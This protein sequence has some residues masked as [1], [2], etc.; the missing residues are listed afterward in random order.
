MLK[1]RAATNSDL[2]RVAALVLSIQ[3]DEF[4][5][6][7]TREDQPDLQDLESVFN[8]GRGVFLVILDG[9]KIVGTIGLL[10]AGEGLGVLRK[11]FVAPAYR[12]REWGTA[13][14]LLDAF[15]KH[16]RLHEFQVV[17]L[18][19]Q[20]RLA[21]ACRFYEKH[22]FSEIAKDSMHKNFPFMAVDDRF[23]SLEL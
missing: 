10:D 7:I 14:L 8:V 1:I 23:Y 12:G 20:R 6:P 9:E 15:L 17:Q 21:A 5:V 18:G 4:N 11:M 2:D 13:K 16:A 22:G 19:T 3:I